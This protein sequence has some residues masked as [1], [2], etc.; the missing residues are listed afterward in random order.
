MLEPHLKHASTWI[1][2]VMI[3]LFVAGAVALVACRGR[4]GGDAAKMVFANAAGMNDLALPA[5]IDSAE[6]A[7][8]VATVLWR[9][10]AVRAE[11][12]L[13]AGVTY[14]GWEAR[15][16]WASDSTGEDWSVSLRS[17]GVLPHFGCTVVLPANEPVEA[18]VRRAVECSYA[19]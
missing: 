5:T 17:M 3:A 10:E 16:L 18:A 9:N 8:A 12:R 1:A 2:V 15:A 4:S 19:K 13:T 14:D 6:A 7:I 11:K